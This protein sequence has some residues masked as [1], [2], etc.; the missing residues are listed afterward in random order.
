MK[1]EKVIWEGTENNYEKFKSLNKSHPSF[2][3]FEKFIKMS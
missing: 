1:M 2:E 3:L